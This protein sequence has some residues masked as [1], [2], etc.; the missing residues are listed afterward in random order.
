MLDDIRVL[1]I[2]AP[3]T[4]MAGRIL[5]DLGAEVV[6]LEPPGGAPGRRME[7]FLDNLP[8]LERSLTWY[9]LNRNKR[10]FTLD[11]NTA[12]GRELAIALARNFDAIIET[13]APGGASPLDKIDLPEILVRCTI[14]AFAR[15]GP[16]SDYL[17]TDLVVMASSGAPAMTG[18]SDRPPLFYSVPQSIME[19]GSEAAIAILAAVVGRDRGAPGQRT[20]VSARIAAMMS[21][22]S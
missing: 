17:A 13:A 8:G 20:E 22:M 10:A 1:E 9:A 6:V 5:A 15:S 11:L 21:S 19:A 7:P 18:D 4:M 12:D 14:S 16:K 2:S 3:E